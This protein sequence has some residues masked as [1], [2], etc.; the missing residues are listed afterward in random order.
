MGILAIER[1]L[2]AVA[3]GRRV[4]VVAIPSRRS[5]LF[6]RRRLEVEVRRS[7]RGQPRLG[8]GDAFRDL[9]QRQIVDPEGPVEIKIYGCPVRRTPAGV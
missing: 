1:H 4:E 6:L 7:L 5:P 3:S 2:I 8:A 9:L